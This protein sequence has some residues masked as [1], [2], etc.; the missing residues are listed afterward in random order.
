MEISI[1]YHTV[2]LDKGGGRHLYSLLTGSFSED[3]PTLKLQNI[4]DV[5]IGVIWEKI[6]RFAFNIDTAAE[7][8][9]HRVFTVTVDSKIETVSMNCFEASGRNI[10]TEQ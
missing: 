7:W 1:L 8:I 4:D 5:G 10:S 6:E 2:S 9:G 3:L